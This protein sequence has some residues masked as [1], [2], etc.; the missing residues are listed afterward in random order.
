MTRRLLDDGAAAAVE[1]ALVVP[2]LLLIL[3]G[4]V[5]FGRVYNA[6][7]ALSASAREAARVMAVTEDPIAAVDAAIDGAPSLSPA[8]EPSQV[9][10]TPASCGPGVNVAVDITYPMSL[11]PIVGGFEIDVSG[12][13]VMRCG[14]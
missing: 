13:G 7:I 9:A 11:L 2:F 3:F 14:G 6:Q 8:L 5:E 4:I 12:R 1:F 10:I